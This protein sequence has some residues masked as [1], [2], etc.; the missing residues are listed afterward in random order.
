M[1]GELEEHRFETAI[2][3][4]INKG[5]CWVDR[6]LGADGSQAESEL[7]YWFPSLYTSLLADQES[8]SQFGDDMDLAMLD[9]RDLD[10]Q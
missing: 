10:L 2:E 4:L 8:E 5:I 6:G 3:Q 1:K 7:I 9:D